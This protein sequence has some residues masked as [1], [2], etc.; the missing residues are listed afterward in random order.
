VFRFGRGAWKKRFARKIV[1][2]KEPSLPESAPKI[3]QK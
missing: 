1:G 3:K 2:N